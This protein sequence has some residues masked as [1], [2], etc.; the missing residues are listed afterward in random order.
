[1]GDRL[2]PDAPTSSD[3]VRS[4]RTGDDPAQ[5]AAVADERM[6]EWALLGK[7][8]SSPMPPRGLDLAELR[9][10]LCLVGR[11]KASLAAFEADVVGEITRLE[12]EAGAS[13]IVRRD[14]K[15]SRGDAKR[16]VKTAAQLEWAPRVAERLA[17]GA[18]TPEAAGLIADAASSGVPV[19]QNLLLDAAESEPDDLFRRIL[20][21]HVNERTSDEELEAR[22]E[23]QRRNRQASISEQ[24]DGMV[25]LFASLD[26][27]AGARL[28]GA[29]RAKADELFRT[30]DP[31]QRST[32]PQ[33]LADA[34][35]QLVC[36]SGAGAPQ[37]AELLVLADYDQ[38][39]DAITNARLTDGTRLTEAETLAIACDAK[40]LPGI[41]NKHTGNP[42]LGRSQ[43]K[44]SPRH[45]KR[46]IA[47][48]GGC[49]GCAASEKIC[50]V[51][52]LDHWAH[53]GKTTLDNTC[54]L[55]WRCHHIRVHLHG[56][57]ITRHPNGHLTLAPPT[58]GDDGGSGGGERTS[59][60]PPHNH[61]RH[62]PHETA[63]R[64]RPNTQPGRS[65]GPCQQPP[66]PTPTPRRC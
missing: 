19:D 8:Q 28:R 61:H 66:L 36:G 9:E 39:H 10:R 11:A 29:L 45:R 3:P 62:R 38:T 55:C 35:E 25:N 34:L 13:E 33:R 4:A 24:P 15:R 2:A 17:A 59:R 50:E 26:P 41:F 16:V 54:L 37:G 65:A 40:I 52:H 23:R 12:G 53:G 32:A 14:Q 57:E 22:R 47:R 64:T 1:M 58:S 7:W 63:T 6:R 31:Q 48:D 44:V 21:E 51:H 27:L 56:E 42:I 18:I 43:R 60:P 30:E 46:L 5:S 20:K 49:I